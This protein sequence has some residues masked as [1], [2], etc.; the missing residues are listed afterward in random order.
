MVPVNHDRF[1]LKDFDWENLS[2]LDSHDHLREVVAVRRWSHMEVQQ[3]LKTERS[4][5]VP[6]LSCWVQHGLSVLWKIFYNGI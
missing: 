3:Y 1:Q 6:C 4:C 2:I 5:A